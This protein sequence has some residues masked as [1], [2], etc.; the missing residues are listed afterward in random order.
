[1]AVCGPN[2]PQHGNKLWGSGAST[3]CIFHLP[4][5]HQ[6]GLVGAQRAHA[7]VDVSPGQLCV[8]GGIC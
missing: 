5:C 6:A 2:A 1:M 7:V 4:L 3:V 8:S